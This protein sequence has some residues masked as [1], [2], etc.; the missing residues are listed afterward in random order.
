MKDTTVVVERERLT[1]AVPTDLKRQVRAVL[2]LQGRDW[3][4]LMPELLEKWL[5]EQ[6]PTQSNN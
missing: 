2:A 5:K 1:V 3:T 6:Q 4:D